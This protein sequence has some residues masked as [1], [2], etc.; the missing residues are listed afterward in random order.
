M[1]DDSRAH[2]WPG[3]DSLTAYCRCCPGDFVLR[4]SWCSDS[5]ASF[6]RS[7]VGGPQL[8]RR[9]FFL[10][11][12]VLTVLQSP[13]EGEGYQGARSWSGRMISRRRR[14]YRG[15]SAERAPAIQP[16]PRI[17]ARTFSAYCCFVSFQR[18]AARE[19]RP[20]SGR[21]QSTSF[22]FPSFPAQPG[23]SAFRSSAL[24]FCRQASCRS[25]CKR[26]P[27]KQPRR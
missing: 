24:N 20:Y 8:K 18:I 22:G 14:R 19:E 7:Q 9:S 26:P 4:P 23:Q 13:R 12:V 10:Q 21:H 17:L 3:Y 15:L 27:G 2:A 6:Q 25:P 16:P 5:R 11:I 1:L